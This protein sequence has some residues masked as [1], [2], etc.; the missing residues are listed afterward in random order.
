MAVETKPAN[1]Q[2]N[3]S[4]ASST[5]T[6]VPPAAS[7]TLT[8]MPAVT[9]KP[10]KKRASSLLAVATSLPSMETSLEEF[11]ARANSSDVDPSTWDNAER[12][13]REEDEKRKEADALRWKAAEDQLRDGQQREVHLKSKL[14]GLQGKLAEAEARVAVAMSSSNIS[15]TA[16]EAAAKSAEL[17]E[18]KVKLAAAEERAQSLSTALVAAKQDQHKRAETTELVMRRPSSFGDDRDDERVA[19]AEAKAAKA[20]AAAKAAAAGLTVSQAD[21]AAIESGLVVTDFSPTKR[22]PWL[23]IGGAFLGGIAIMF[24]V[25]KFMNPPAAAPTVP[26]VAQPAPTQT[27]S[28]PTPAPAAAVTPPAQQAQTA[29]AKAEPTR[30]TATPIDE[31]PATGPTV[32]PTVQPI[33]TPPEPPKAAAVVVEKK[34]PVVHHTTRRAAPAPAPATAAAAPAGKGIVDPFADKSDAP[35]AEAPKKE[36]AKAADK[37]GIVDPF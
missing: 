24:A 31:A 23:A 14:D 17:A 20:I 33:E 36:A 25:S 26:A 2:S 7:G 35:K 13:A 4:S 3:G 34:A 11:I 27:Q 5:M 1:G 8:G 22:T 37:S 30:V 29:P 12:V 10:R 19:I 9:A 28:T 6:G 18:I 21:I 15:A 32:Q 16:I